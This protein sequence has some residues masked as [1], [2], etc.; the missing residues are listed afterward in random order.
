MCVGRSEDL[1]ARHESGVIVSGKLGTRVDF[2]HLHIMH[3]FKAAILH[4][5]FYRR[6]QHFLHLDSP[7]FGLSGT[8]LSFL[9]GLLS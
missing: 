9:S 4:R 1:L 5:R 2:S 8:R 3:G 6:Q 7:T